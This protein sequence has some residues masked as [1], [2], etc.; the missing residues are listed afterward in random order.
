[1]KIFKLILLFVLFKSLTPAHLVQKPIHLMKNFDDRTIDLQSRLLA[2]EEVPPDDEDI[3]DDIE[4]T[5]E[6]N[7]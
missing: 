6:T 2:D 3:D 4:D 5:I 1:M 7:D